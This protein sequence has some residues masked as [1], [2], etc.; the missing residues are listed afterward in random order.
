LDRKNIDNKKV[1]LLKTLEGNIIVKHKEMIEKLDNVKQLFK[2]NVLPDKPT[3]TN[4]NNDK[5]GKIII[6]LNEA[7]ELQ[8]NA[9]TSIESMIDVVHHDKI[10]KHLDL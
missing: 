7:K 9:Y 2:S 4:M 5:I 3:N 10:W 6:L 8:R 1:K